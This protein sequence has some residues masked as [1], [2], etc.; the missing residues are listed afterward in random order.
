MHT[1][2][3]IRIASYSKPRSHPRN[4]GCICVENARRVQSESHV[5]ANHD[6]A[7]DHSLKVIPNYFIVYRL[8]LLLELTHTI[9]SS[10][11][12]IRARARARDRDRIAARPFPI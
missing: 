4:S 9:H 5:A 2:H 6:D 10:S 7:G 11:T 3:F 12:L 8:L 1:T